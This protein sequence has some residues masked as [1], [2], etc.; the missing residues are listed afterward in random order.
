MSSLEHRIV[1]DGRYKLLKKF[2]RGAHAEL[3]E[4]QQAGF[5]GFQRLVAMKVVRITPEVPEISRESLLREGRLA[6]ILNHPNI[7][8]IF[9][10]GA[11][12]DLVYIAMEYVR[13]LD[14][15]RCLRRHLERHQ[16][17]LPWPIVARLGALI[18]RGLGHA[19]E[20]SDTLG[21]P[22]RI[23][24]R[25][26]K[27]S[28]VIL[29]REGIVKL[30][31]F[32]IA[33]SFTLSSGRSLDFKG[34][35]AY[36]SPEQIMG[37]EIDHRS[38]LFSFGI[39][40]YELLLGHRPFGIKG[41]PFGE[42]MQAILQPLHQTPKEQLPSLPSTFNDLILRLLEKEPDQRPS[43]A[44][45][46]YSTLE[47][48]LRE[49]QHYIEQENLA[50]FCLSLLQPP[51]E[52]DNAATHSFQAIEHED[53]TS[54][55]RSPYHYPQETP[56]P[57]ETPK[58]QEDPDAQDEQVDYYKVTTHL[59][60]LRLEDFLPPK[61][62]S[63]E[64][65]EGDL[66]TALIAQPPPTPP[67]I[68]E[69]SSEDDLGD[70]TSLSMP[71]P[72]LET[73]EDPGD[74][75]S[76]SLGPQSSPQNAVR[77]TTSH[78]EDDLGDQTS[79]LV[80]MTAH[81]A[82]HAEKNQDTASSSATSDNMDA[83]SDNMETTHRPV[84]PR[85][86]SNAETIHIPIHPQ[87]VDDATAPKDLPTTSHAKEPPDLPT[88]TTS[89]SQ[90]ALPALAATLLSENTSFPQNTPP[91][92]PGF[93][94]PSSSANKPAFAGNAERTNPN[95]QQH[96]E[97]TN[98]NQNTHT[99]LTDP[100]SNVN[101]YL[102]PR[103]QTSRFFIP[104]PSSEK[105]NPSQ[106]SNSS[107]LVGQAADSPKPLWAPAKTAAKPTPPPQRPIPSRHLPPASSPFTKMTPPSIPPSQ[108]VP[109]PLHSESTKIAPPST[110]SKPGFWIFVIALSL[111]AGGVL[112]FLLRIRH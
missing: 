64:S 47:S 66:P 28:N 36:V 30:I 79:L 105:T 51:S 7:V 54:I 8:Q 70:Q 73:D 13:G 97:R 58:P 103:D 61:V 34:T 110:L 101:N 22:L 93:H 62:G 2:A 72:P 91:P 75:T 83:A 42:I 40:L 59:P 49:E 45:E 76:L 71:T 17:P 95:L 6:A 56:V 29:S 21:T 77:T 112:A 69:S 104:P 52:Q 85:V 57:Q 108:M 4:A 38:D 26:I 67:A 89:R 96:A 27:P 74:Q 23:V 25:D 9:D 82:W 94:V 68:T 109:S 46:I 20:Q 80:G 19:H 33:K 12:S 78:D 86:D 5:E 16:T 106:P 41:A 81:E 14:L 39:L 1:A 43:S 63:I 60:G 100:S 15:R 35:V 11:E 65:D 55:S 31:D 50:D 111:I 32:G 3:W 99:E 10:V 107:S 48:L 98:P 88:I 24:H 53:S 92:S 87:E 44:R 37:K 18:A 102:E 84:I 90:G